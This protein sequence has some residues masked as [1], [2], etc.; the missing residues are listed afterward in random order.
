MR[1]K[2]SVLRATKRVLAHG[3]RTAF[4]TI[5]PIPGLSTRDR[6]RANEIGPPAAAVRT[7]YESL[8]RSA[9]FYDVQSQDRTS[10]YR[11]ALAG[12]IAAFASRHR[13]VRKLIGDD[14]YE[15]RAQSRSQTLEAVEQGLLGRFLYS[16][17][18]P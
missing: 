15:E 8:L 10:E 18:R 5:Q 11:D 13:E 9:G 1:T 6:R 16:A 3:G 14:V 17:T 2:L 7:S 4:L 12:W